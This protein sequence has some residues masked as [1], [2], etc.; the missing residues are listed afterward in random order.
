MGLLLAVVSFHGWSLVDLA[1]AI[2]I[3]AAIVACVFIALRKF[4]LTIPEWVTA[5][6]WIV[7]VAFVVIFAIELLAGM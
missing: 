1:K 2:V 5:I 3:I 6:F 7:V 4:G